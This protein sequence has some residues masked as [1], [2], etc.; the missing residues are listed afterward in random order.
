MSEHQANAEIR[1]GSERSFGI[2]F[3]VVFALVGLWPLT[4]DGGPRWWALAVA[5][6]FLAVA[7][8]RPAL[9]RPL[10]RAWFR[11]GLLLGRIVSPVVMGLIFVLTVI[12]TGLIRRLRDRDPLRQRF[13]PEARS[14]WIERDREA[15]SRSSMRKQF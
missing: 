9:L 7:L 6:G 2:V 3:C 4:G 13:D 11:F 14:Y 15:A 12:P 1:M 10:N 8:A 5:A